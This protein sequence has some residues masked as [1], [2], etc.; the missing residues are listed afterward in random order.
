[1]L[2]TCP[3]CGTPNQEPGKYCENCGVLIPADASQASPDA[4]A[5]PAGTAPDAQPAPADTLPVTAPQDAST[6]DAPAAVQTP[7]AHFAVV[8]GDQANPQEG[9]TITRPGEF[10]VGRVDLDTQTN[11]DIDLRQWVS[12][13]EVG[14]QKQYLVH[15]KQC[16]VGLGADGQATI[17]PVPGTEN[18]TLI[19]P[20][21]ATEY[22][23]LSQLSTT[24]QPGSDSSLPLQIGD[25]LYMGDP[26][27]LQFFLSNDPTAEGTYVVLELLSA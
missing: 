18:D 8:H 9:F 5:Q 10:L 2:V 20:A 11:V 6:G 21:G 16:Y 17:R 24:R 4:A 1:V 14:G 13:I 22:M 23:P 12:P 26:E 19:R 15:R 27:A 25:R 3:Q 7:Q